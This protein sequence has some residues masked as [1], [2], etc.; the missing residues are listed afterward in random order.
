[1]MM[2]IFTQQTFNSNALIYNASGLMDNKVACDRVVTIMLVITVLY[3][4]QNQHDGRYK[5]HGTEHFQ[6]L[7]VLATR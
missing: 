7:I 2:N 6:L 4:N 1:M 5:L 3:V